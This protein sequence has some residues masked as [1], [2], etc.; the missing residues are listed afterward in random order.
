MTRRWAVLLLVTMI[1]T[2]PG[3][4]GLAN[5]QRIIQPPRFNQAQDRPAELSI[6][7]PSLSNP[8]GGAG[9]TV[10]LQV[11]NPNAFGFTLSRLDTTLLVE[12]TRAATGDFPLG[13]PL[14]AGQTS[15]IPLDLTIS[16]ADLP[17]LG[18]AIQRA[19][20][21][22]AIAY[23]LEGTVGVDAGPL[24]QPAFGPLRLV[25]GELRVGRR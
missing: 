16:F 14:G 9:V 17:A 13:L 23:E 24:G 12:G 7:A 4:G 8:L 19:T 5:L 21:G 11:T 3:C 10:W 25:A 1:G 15:V 22:D 2:V 20:T 18:A 6:S